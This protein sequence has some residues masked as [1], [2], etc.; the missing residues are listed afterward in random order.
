MAD[1][2]DL[3]QLSRR[4]LL[5]GLAAAGCETKPKKAS[6]TGPRIVSISPNT[7]ETLFALGAGRHVVGRSKFC[8]HPKQA[9]AVPSVG[10]Y[11]DSSFEAILGL[12]PDLVTGARG[13][14]GRGL[15]DR[16]TERGVA[17]Y[18]P[19]TE[20]FSEILEMIR[21][22]G[23]RAQRQRQATEL[24]NQLNRERA[25][26]SAAVKP[27]ARPRALLVF[28]LRPI[29]VAG[30]KSFPDEMVSTA[31]GRNCVDSGPRYPTIS[32][33]R[34]L[35][36]DPDV[37]LDATVAATH[38]G[39]GI[40]KAAPGWKD[41]KAIRRDRLVPLADSSVLRPGPRINRGLRLIAKALHPTAQ[42][43][44]K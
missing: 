22:L 26:I 17:T 37:V 41:I 42:G 14:A 18:F 44:V 8:D 16:L 33:E 3:P 9:L 13:P 6:E 1:V 2:A 36:L 34:L 35:A 20:N 30:P 15:V 38:D 43:L 23:A 28:G 39:A 24:Q 4:A 7:T 19:S 32:V 21:G 40:S 27:L 12:A 5:A 31:G 29:V 25:A 11:V 10:G